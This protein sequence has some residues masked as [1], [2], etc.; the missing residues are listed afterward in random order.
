MQNFFPDTLVEDL[1]FHSQILGAW[2]TA[3]W[4]IEI[5]D[6]WLFRNALDQFGIRPREEG[7]LIGILFAPMLHGGFQHLS[8]NTAPLLVLGW[9]V[10]LDGPRVFAIVTTV[11]WV[12]GGLGVWL[13][14]RSPSVHVGVSGVIFGYLGYLLS[15]GY[16]VQSPAAIA[17][18]V[19][20]G[21]LYGGII[22]GVL[23]LRR[24][25]SWE[26]H[27]CGF[28]SGGLAAYYLDQIAVFIYP[29]V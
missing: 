29:Y 13:F 18:A 28:L 7:G 24:G 8:A 9:F 25:S 3:L 4:V 26:G 17:L 10:L 5:L 2:I 21:F 27:L 15:R 20:S 6:Q 19:I 12:V 14:G 1:V 16:L 22:W 23:P 11:V